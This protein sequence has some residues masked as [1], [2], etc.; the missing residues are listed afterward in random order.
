[1]YTQTNKLHTEVYTESMN[2]TKQ[3]ETR[4]DT[5]EQR[6]TCKTLN[7]RIILTEIGSYE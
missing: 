3:T 5:F 2:N 1:M 4:L 6:E 7:I